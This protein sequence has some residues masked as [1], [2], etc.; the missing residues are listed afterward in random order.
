MKLV[1]VI[2]QGTQIEVAAIS[3]ISFRNHNYHQIKTWNNRQRPT[4]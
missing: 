4:V 1:S 2:C 3:P